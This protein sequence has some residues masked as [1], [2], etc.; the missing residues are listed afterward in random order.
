MSPSTSVFLAPTRSSPTPALTVVSSKPSPWTHSLQI[1]CNGFVG[2]GFHPFEGA[3]SENRDS[4][5]GAVCGKV[6]CAMVSIMVCKGRIIPPSA[7]VPSKGLWWPVYCTIWGGT[8]RWFTALG[9]SDVMC[10]ARIPIRGP[11]PANLVADPA[12]P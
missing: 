8:A 2:P 9:T 4:I 3:Q 10:L 5:I 12:R 7:R 1:H 11:T 6:A